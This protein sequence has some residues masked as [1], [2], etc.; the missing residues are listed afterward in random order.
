MANL[1]RTDLSETGGLDIGAQIRERLIQDLKDEK[2]VLYFQSIVPVAVEATDKALHREIL[3]RFK[4]EERDLM[5]P[6]MFLPML[7]QH[8][9]MPLL[10]R[11]V[12]GR[13]VRW[14]RD[15]HAAGTPRYAPRCSINLS[16]DTVRRDTAFGDF[17][18]QSVSRLA[19]PPGSLSFEIPMTE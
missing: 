16:S 7:E 4:E 12:T 18:Q 17:V 5:P 13:V 8:S 3:I 10:D 6:G 9:L 11:W 19:I 14:V 2:F 15:L 1:M